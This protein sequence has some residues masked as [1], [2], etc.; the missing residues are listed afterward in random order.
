MNLPPYLLFGNLLLLT[1]Q[2]RAMGGTETQNAL[3]QR[4]DG[5]EW[6]RVE[7]GEVCVVA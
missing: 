7:I 4:C 1:I 2:A 5:G 3:L 6:E